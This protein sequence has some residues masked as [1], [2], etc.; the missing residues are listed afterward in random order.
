MQPSNKKSE[1]EGRR[2][3]VVLGLT[4]AEI[5]LLILFAVVLAMAGVLAKRKA[6]IQ[7]EANAMLNTAKAEKTIPIDPAVYQVGL[8]FRKLFGQKSVQEVLNEL[9]RLQADFDKLKSEMAK[10][11]NTEVLPPC[12]RNANGGQAPYIYEIRLKNDGYFLVD[13][14]PEKIKNQLRNEIPG[15]VPLDRV[16]STSEF[17][18]ATNPYINY[19]K[20][21]Q[22]KFYVKVYDDSQ[23][24]REKIKNQ[25]KVIESNFVW[26]F[27]LTIKPGSQNSDDL[28]LFQTNPTI[29]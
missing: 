2:T 17:K 18:S 26:T 11:S 21:N 24:G 20:R 29:R 12:F 16:L 22:C 25:L 15:Q 28:N 23:A 6:M 27:I 1:E 4:I 10:L 8:D 7:A 13:T 9:N 19:G 5:I 3:G 14:A